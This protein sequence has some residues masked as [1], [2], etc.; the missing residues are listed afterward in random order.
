MPKAHQLVCS[1]TKWQGREAYTLSNGLIQMVNLTGGGHIAE[2]RFA[3]ASGL[4]TLNP[5]WAP[6]WKSMEPFQ[7]SARSHAKRYGPLT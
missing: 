3:E 2:L 7:Y 6:P 4:P 1:K 5:L